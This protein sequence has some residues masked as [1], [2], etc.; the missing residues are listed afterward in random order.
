[1]CHANNEKRK[2]MTEE[3]ELPNQ[4]KSERSEKRKITRSG[5]HQTSGDERKNLK[6]IPQ[7]NEK[8]T[9]SQTI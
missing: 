8:T 4:E 2:K 1:M 3:I 7:E 5:Y 6:R 9:R